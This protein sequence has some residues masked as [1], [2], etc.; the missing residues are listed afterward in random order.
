MLF[1]YAL[2]RR[3]FSAQLIGAVIFLTVSEAADGQGIGLAGASMLAAAAKPALAACLGRDMRRDG[4][5][6]LVLV[7][8]DS[9]FAMAVT[10]TLCLLSTERDTVSEYFVS[11]PALAAFVVLTSSL[12]AFCYNLVVYSLT[13]AA[14]PVVSVIASNFKQVVLIVLAGILVDRISHPLNWVGIAFF[15]VATFLYSY[16]ALNQ[17]PPSQVATRRGAHGVAPAAAGAHGAPPDEPPPRTV[18]WSHKGIAASASTASETTPLRRPGD[19]PQP[20]APWYAGSG[21]AAKK[22]KGAVLK[23]GVPCPCR[24]SSRR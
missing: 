14:S 9:L 22:G 1:A 23:A 19:A 6:P 18:R 12:L 10:G 17:P 4:L 15:F 8:W 20:Q 2:Q 13:T 5:T 21:R 7:W 3:T 11:K 16:L 24:L